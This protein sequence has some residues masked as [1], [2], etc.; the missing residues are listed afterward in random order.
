MG[1]YTKLLSM[2]P[3]PRAAGYLQHT[4]TAEAFA[5]AF[6]FFFNCLMM[7]FVVGVVKLH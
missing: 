1:L 3:S 4:S 5:R 2:F 6:L 7:F